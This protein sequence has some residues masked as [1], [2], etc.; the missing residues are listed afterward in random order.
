MSSFDPVDTDA[1]RALG[2]ELRSARLGLQVPGDEMIAAA[3][4]VDRLRAE[5]AECDPPAAPV[6]EAMGD[7]TREIFRLRAV[8]VN[9]PHGDRC[10]SNGWYDRGTS[11]FQVGPCTCWKADALG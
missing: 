10:R 3:D 7:A 8:I 1:L 9:A 5:L 2:A 4:E 6:L 11:A